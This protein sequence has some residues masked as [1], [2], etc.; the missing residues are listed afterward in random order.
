MDESIISMKPKNAQLKKE[1]H[2]VNHIQIDDA[3]ERIKSI[4]DAK[5][6]TCWNTKACLR[7]HCYIHMWT[8]FY[9]LKNHKCILD[10]SLGRWKDE[11]YKIEPKAVPIPYHAY[12]V[13][14]PKAHKATLKL[15]IQRL[16]DL[17][18]LKKVNRSKWVAPAFL[19]GFQQLHLRTK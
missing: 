15:E 16:R 2:N 6:L 19:S 3:V 11:K 10:D 8:A 12:P 18:V 17:G 13:L 14:V 9:V 1:I 4:M 5:I 7:K